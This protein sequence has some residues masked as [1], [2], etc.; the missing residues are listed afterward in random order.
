MDIS[1]DKLQNYV[2][3]LRE[4]T[5]DT[6]SDLGHLMTKVAEGVSNAIRRREARTNAEFK[7]IGEQIEH[8]FN[9]N[10]RASLDKTEVQAAKMT[11]LR[12]SGVDEAELPNHLSEIP[13]GSDSTRIG[14]QSSVEADTER[15][16]LE[17]HLE[18]G[19]PFEPG[20]KTMHVNSSVQNIAASVKQALGEIDPSAA[21]WVEAK[22]PSVMLASAL[23]KAER[24]EDMC[25]ITQP[26]AAAAFVHKDLS[27]RTGDA[28]YFSTAKTRQILRDK[29]CSPSP[30]T[31]G[32]PDALPDACGRPSWAYK[33][34]GITWEVQPGAQGERRSTSPARFPSPTRFPPAAFPATVDKQLPNGRYLV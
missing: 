2:R 16:A 4:E 11:A 32:L 23:H 17:R 18:S 15:E 12:K 27:S 10:S 33:A 7:R 22:T 14:S 5:N 31:W 19:K 13:A 9:L 3:S 26:V 21:S 29:Q 25:R 20:H 8:A 24:V 1:Q 6:L 30:K 34:A 28:S